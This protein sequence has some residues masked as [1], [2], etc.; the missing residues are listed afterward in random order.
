MV[1]GHV[2]GTILGFVLFIIIY[3]FDHY[4]FYS[5]YSM[6]LQQLNI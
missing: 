6:S 5:F 2:V 3:P 4:Y 1:L